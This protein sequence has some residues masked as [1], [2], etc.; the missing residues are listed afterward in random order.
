MT[1]A[2][3]GFRHLF[4]NSCFLRALGIYFIPPYKFFNLG[5]E[6]PVLAPKL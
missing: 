3:F 6:P 2:Y 4:F 1:L 5:E